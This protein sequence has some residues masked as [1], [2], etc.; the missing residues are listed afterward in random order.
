MI[1]FEHTVFALPF[2]LI[3][4]LLASSGLPEPGQIAWIVAAMVGARSAAMTFNRIVDLAYDRDNPRTR[5]RALAQGTLTLG[6]AVGFTVVMSALF[7]FSAAMLNRLCLY[8]SFP[9]L[10]I[11]FSYSYSKRFTS[12]SHLI[13]GFAIGLAPPGAWLAIRGE[14]DLLPVLLGLAVMFW[15]A[16]FDIIYACQDANFDRARR[17]FSLPASWGLPAALRVSLALHAATIALLVAV[18]R[19]GELGGL[20]YAG[21]AVTA[22]ILWWEHRIVAPDDLSRVDVAF[23][24]MNGYVSLLLLGAFA[25]DILVL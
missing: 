17:L 12:M 8:L 16:G 3:A 20:A 1:K 18:A 7:V 9:V 11:L 4:A 2:A 22:A 25:A 14:F 13:L 5:T 10:G 21:I 23:F 6:F 19:V 24:T 15:I